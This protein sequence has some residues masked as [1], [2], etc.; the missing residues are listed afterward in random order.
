MHCLMFV[1][2]EEESST[3]DASPVT[4]QPEGSHM[5]ESEAIPMPPPPSESTNLSADSKPT[6]GSEEAS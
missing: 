6:Y 2:Q 3:P 5:N 1:L 4:T